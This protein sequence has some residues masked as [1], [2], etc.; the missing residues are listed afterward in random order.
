MLSV[1]KDNMPRFF[2][3]YI[4]VAAAFFI[5]TVMW[6]SL[7]A[8]GIFFGPLLKEFGW[9]R[10][11]TSGAFSLSFIMFGLLGMISGR[12]S[13]RF[14]PK[15]VV[16]F[17]G[18]VLGIAFIMISRISS[19]WQIY[20][21]Y[22][23]IVAIGMSGCVVPLAS[24]ISRWF[25]ARRGMMTGIVVS[26]VGAG[27]LIVPMIANQLLSLYDWRTSY[28]I[29]GI[30]I[31]VL[32]ILGAQFI[33]RDPNQIGQLPLGKKELSPKYGVSAEGLTLKEAIRTRQ[34]WMIG[35]AFFCF[36]LGLGSIMVHIVPHTIELGI[37]AYNAAI[38]LN[39]IGGAS[40]IS[41]TSMGMAGD[42][43]GYKLVVIIG[44]ALL[45]VSML[46]LL[47][48]DKLWQLYFLAFVFGFGYGSA[49]VGVFPLAAEYFGLISHGSIIGF[50]LFGGESGNAIGPAFTGYIYDVNGSYEAAF[51]TLAATSF[52]GI[53]L[54]FCLRPGHL[55]D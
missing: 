15:I 21:Y 55:E 32:V 10:A 23:V 11:M 13:D 30:S 40:V 7:Y 5:V 20:L 31:I 26:G 3:G 44:L 41:R 27:T 9:T 17:C 24:T 4:V 1:N 18:S 52:I 8:F 34:L 19:L 29:L 38:V 33:K 12:L 14:G 46:W 16:I 25:I 22:G 50:L 6:G 45:S 51:I 47:A 53:I 43:I 35:G 28:F 36:T 49:S 2:Y 39:I 54:V 37:P 42:K 48:A